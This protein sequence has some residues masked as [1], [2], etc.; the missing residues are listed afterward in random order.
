MCSGISYSEPVVKSIAL[1]MEEGTT[2]AG[3]AGAAGT[4]AE[5]LTA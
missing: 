2:S 5:E 1:S 3:G 4:A